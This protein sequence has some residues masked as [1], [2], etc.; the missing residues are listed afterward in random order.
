MKDF[1][2]YNVILSIVLNEASP[3]FSA[4]CG[5]GCGSGVCIRDDTCRCDDSHYGACCEK[6]TIREEFSTLIYRTV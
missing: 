6:G 5:H 3:I 4:K 2:M 1:E